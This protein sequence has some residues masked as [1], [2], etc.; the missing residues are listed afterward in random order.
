VIERS[1]AAKNIGSDEEPGD[2]A[3]LAVEFHFDN[4]SEETAIA[5][6]RP[7][8]ATPHDALDASEDGG[9]LET[10]V[11]CGRRRGIGGNDRCAALV[12]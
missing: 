4:T 10:T 1:A 7:E 6:A 5:L 9:A 11:G 2:F 12:C 8:A 3:T